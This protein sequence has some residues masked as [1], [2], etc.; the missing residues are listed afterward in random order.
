MFRVVHEIFVVLPFTNP[1]VVLL[2]R[3]QRLVGSYRVI[4]KVPEKEQ[5]ITDW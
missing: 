3:R 4:A 2:E 1:T 5:K